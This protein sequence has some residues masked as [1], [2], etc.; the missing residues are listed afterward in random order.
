[1]S[2]EKALD[3]VLDEF[4]KIAEIPRPSH[5]EEKIAEYLYQ[6]AEKRGLAVEKDDL[7]EI[8]I[9]KPAS[10]GCENVPRVI[11]QAHMDMVCVAEEGVVYNPETDPIKVI[12]DGVNLTAEGTSLG[13]DDGIGISVDV[14]VGRFFPERCPAQAAVSISEICVDRGHGGH[15]GLF[16]GR[17]ASKV[18]F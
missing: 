15:S 17:K 16:S 18:C 12:N 9:D 5:H 10:A 6:W 13:A 7:G 8:I 1:M 4:M 14:H 3:I 2:K 11:F